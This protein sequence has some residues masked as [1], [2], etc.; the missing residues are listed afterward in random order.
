[1]G[2]SRAGAVTKMSNDGGIDG[3]IDQDI[4]GLNRV[5]IQAKR[6]SENNVVGRSDLQGYVGA[7]SGKVDSGVFI[8]TSRHSD[9]ADIDANNVPTRIILID[10]NRLTDLMIRYGVGVQVRETYKIV[11][12][13]EDFFA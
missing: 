8:T 9:D 3:V 5:Y 12:I 13:D 4:L 1:G 7:L 2:T 10:G 11:E 6:Y